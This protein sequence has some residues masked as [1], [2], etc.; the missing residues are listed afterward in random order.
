MYGSNNNSSEHN[1]DTNHN[2][3]AKLR[4]TQ[5]SLAFEAL[6]SSTTNAI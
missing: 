2:N 6:S 5:E 1:S 4:C 3:S